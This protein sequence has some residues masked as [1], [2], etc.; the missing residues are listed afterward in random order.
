MAHESGSVPLAGASTTGAE[1]KSRTAAWHGAEPRRFLVTVAA[2]L[3]IWALPVPQGS[4]KA[5]RPSSGLGLVSLRQRPG[6][7]PPATGDPFN[8]VPELSVR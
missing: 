5:G 7:S 6:A 3:V 2:G 1:Q 4:E 8:R